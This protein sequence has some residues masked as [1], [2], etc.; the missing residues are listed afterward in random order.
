[1]ST[2]ERL[3]ADSGGRPDSII[4]ETNTGTAARRGRQPALPIGGVAGDQL[5]SPKEEAQT[6]KRPPSAPTLPPKTI[7]LRPF[8]RGPD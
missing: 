1:M 5:R 6:R 4:R 2:N 7:Q 3:R 8:P